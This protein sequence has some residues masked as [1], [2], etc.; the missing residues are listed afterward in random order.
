MSAIHATFYL[1]ILFILIGVPIIAVTVI[2]WK[3]RR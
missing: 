2:L 1:I 3:N